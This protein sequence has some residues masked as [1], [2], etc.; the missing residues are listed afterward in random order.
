[1]YPG[2]KSTGSKRFDAG[3][4]DQKIEEVKYNNEPNGF[5]SQNE[6]DIKKMYKTTGANIVER[7]KND[8]IWANIGR[9]K[10]GGEDK[11]EEADEFDLV[12]E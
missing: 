4:D 10:E 9:I 1:M 3:D 8:L 11:Q 7:S 2:V 12:G 5:L 6:E